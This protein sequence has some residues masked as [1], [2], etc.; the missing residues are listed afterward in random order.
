MLISRI[1]EDL[2]ERTFDLEKGWINGKKRGI[3]PILICSSERRFYWL[4]TEVLYG[5]TTDCMYLV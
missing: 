5:T 2:N 4:R 3:N 1:S